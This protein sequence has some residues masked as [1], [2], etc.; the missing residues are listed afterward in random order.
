MEPE[1]LQTLLEITLGHKVAK[2]VC[3]ECGDDPFRAVD[4]LYRRADALRAPFR[5]SG[6]Y[7][8]TGHSRASKEIVRM[9]LVARLVDEMN[10]EFREDIDVELVRSIA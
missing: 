3:R 8:D 5:Q 2:D 9:R 10:Y 1:D 6:A 4:L 7:D